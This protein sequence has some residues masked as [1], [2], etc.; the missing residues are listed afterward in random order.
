MTIKEILTETAPLMVM[1][2]AGV[3]IGGLILS[4]RNNQ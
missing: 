4:R 3:I 1:F 2:I